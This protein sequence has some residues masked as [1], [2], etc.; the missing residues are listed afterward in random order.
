M[1]DDMRMRKLSP[2]TQASYIRVVKRLAA[3]LGDHPTRPAPKICAVI[4]CIWLIMAY[5][6]FR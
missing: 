3:F 4:S 6:P 1:I 2:K 5:H